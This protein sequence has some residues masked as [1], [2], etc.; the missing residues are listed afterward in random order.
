MQFLKCKCIMK[1]Y[2]LGVFSF[3][4]CA[5]Y[6]PC[7]F[8]HL[9]SIH[10]LNYLRTVHYWRLDQHPRVHPKMKAYKYHLDIYCS[11][12]FTT[13]SLVPTCVRVWKEEEIK[14]YRFV[15]L[16][17]Y[18]VRVYA[19]HTSLL[20]HDRPFLSPL[21]GMHRQHLRYCCLILKLHRLL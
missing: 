16:H 8:L 4:W 10:N 12:T 2:H 9:C 13:S 5:G 1:H 7:A 3:Y 20:F 19:H 21:H 17:V 11:S 18:A 14:E 6:L 15:I